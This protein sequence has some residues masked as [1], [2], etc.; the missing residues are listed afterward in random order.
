MKK[1]ENV[2]IFSLVIFGKTFDDLEFTGCFS[3]IDF[4]I[5]VY[6]FWGYQG[7][8]EDIQVVCEEITCIN[9]KLVDVM[10]SQFPQFYARI[11]QTMIEKYIE[12]N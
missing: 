10:L 12:L 4:G 3:V 8:D 6:D 11:E 2:Y 1:V 7:T 9:N 5:G